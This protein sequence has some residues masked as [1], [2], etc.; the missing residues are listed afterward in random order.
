MAQGIAPPAH[1]EVTEGFHWT[2]ECIPLGELNDV[3]FDTAEWVGDGQEAH[4]CQ[5]AFLLDGEESL[6]FDTLTQPNGEAVVDLLDDL[7]DGERL[8]YLA[9]SH[10]EANHAGNTFTILDAYPEATLL[11]P[12]GRAGHGEKSEAEHELYH[13]ADDDPVD[14]EDEGGLQNEV[15]HVNDGDGIDLGGFEVA[16]H[17]PV[18]ADHSLT[19]WMT[20]RR[21]NTLFTVDWLGFLHA[22][23]DCVCHV[24][25]FDRP[26]TLE[27]VFRFHALAFPWLRVADLEAVK[28]GVAE[29]EDRFDPDVVAA[30][31]GTVVRDDP[32]AYFELFVEA[33]ERLAELGEPGEMRS[34]LEYVLPDAAEVGR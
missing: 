4:N 13:I 11:V 15:V 5:N 19:T 23:G 26:V 14:G 2:Q 24:D 20:E 6:L 30:A 28:R 27:Q 18:F 16:F 33:A 9:I 12:G 31:H 10:P 3:G 29:I 32:T 8:D 17:E 7:L 22:S 25:E 1:R 34:K 21:T